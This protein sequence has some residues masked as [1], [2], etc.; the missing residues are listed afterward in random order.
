MPDPTDLLSDEAQ[1]R[2]RD[3]ADSGAIPDPVL[4]R[5]NQDIIAFGEELVSVD[6]SPMDFSGQYR[7][8]KQPLRD[9]TDPDTPR[10]HVWPYGRGLGKSVDAGLLYLSV[11][12]SNRMTDALYA[13]PRA[14]QLSSFMNMTVGRMVDNSRRGSPDNPPILRAMLQGS[15]NIKRNQFQTPPAGTGS[16]MESRTAWSDGK[17][18][19]G[20]HGAI[21]VADEFGQWTK[22]ALGNLKNAIDK[23][24]GD[25]S[26]TSDDTAGRVVLTGTPTHEGTVFHEYWEESDQHEWTWPCPDCGQEQVTGMANVQLTST[27]PR[28]WELHCRV[29]DTQVSNEY[30]IESGDWEATNPDG[31]HRGYHMGRLTSPRHSLNEV[32]REYNRPSTSKQQFHNFALGRFYSGAAKPIPS[33]SFQH[34]TDP[35]LTIA[36]RSLGDVAHYF[37]VDWG[38]GEGSETVVVVIHVGQKDDKGFPQDVVV[39]NVIPVTYDS[40]GDELRQVASVLSRFGLGDTGRCVADRGFGSAHVDAMQNGTQ[41]APDVPDRGFGSKVIGHRFSA[42]LSREQGRWDYLKKER[43][44]VVAYK[45]QW[46]NHVID[47]FPDVQGFDQTDHADDVPHDVRRTPDS[48]ITIPYADD[49]DT[50]ERMDYFKQQLTALKREYKSSDESGRKKEYFTTFT[51]NQKDDAVMA[52]VYAYTA[53]VLGSTSGYTDMSVTPK[54][55]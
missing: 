54:T 33:Q 42:N 30:V 23:P 37:G 11:P 12:A 29:C 25:Q 32:M 35:N 49:P 17:A 6:G 13:T 50:R 14:D 21:G 5:A 40:R 39:D 16:V 51:E 44:N 10:H 26:D 47:L 9:A 22:E 48:S 20:F 4:Q 34:A 43:R 52:L 41:D 46:V 53:A 7:Y 31:I 55:G 38:G 27:D 45:P 15:L 36:T 3:G 28:N 24:L 18:L 2:L 1:Q 8:W 19:Q